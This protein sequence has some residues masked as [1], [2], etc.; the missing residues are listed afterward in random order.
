M[1]NTEQLKFSSPEEVNYLD[2][3]DLSDIPEEVQDEAIEILRYDLEIGEVVIN[4]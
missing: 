3:L 1:I 4:E 2:Y